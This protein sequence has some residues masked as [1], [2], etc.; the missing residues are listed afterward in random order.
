MLADAEIVKKVRRLNAH[1]PLRYFLTRPVPENL[2]GSR[3]MLSTGLIMWTGASVN[4]GSGAMTIAADTP[5][6][7][8]ERRLMIPDLPPSSV[9]VNALWFLSITPSLGAS[10]WTTFCQERCMLRL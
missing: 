1:F 6:T 7:K 4:M 2:W 5:T 9:Y 8:L 3:R 10:T